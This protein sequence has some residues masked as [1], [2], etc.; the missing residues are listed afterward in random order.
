[1]DPNTARTR[2]LVLAAVFAAALILLTMLA[3]ALVAFLL[4]PGGPVITEP[5]PAPG[6]LPPPDDSPHLAL[7]NPSG[8]TADP[9]DRD[10]FLMRKPYFA[11]AYN[12]SR[13]TAN[14]VS[15]RLRPSDLGPAPR[16][17]FF[18][19]PDLPSSFWRITPRDYNDS[20]FDRG[21][22]CPR[23]DRSSSP[24]AAQATFVMTNIVPQAPHLNQKAW[25][26]FEDYCRDLAARR[27]Q[28]LYIVAGPQGRGGTGEKGPAETIAGGKVTVPA[29]CWKVVL[30][31]DGPEDAARVG[32]GARLIA[33]VMPNDQSVG[34]GWARYRTSV[35]AVEDLTGYRFFDRVPTTIIEPLKEPVDGGA[36]G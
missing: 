32:P 18:P 9:A 34:H 12:N 28:T 25:A 27:Q 24:E 6:T 21:H 35:R 16:G 29:R 2:K 7:G 4:R 5:E 14:W 1:M 23:G 8:A 33:V 30:A 31:L 17:Q 11:L 13:G 19:D 10:N 3:A 36:G 22:L 26:D 20:G 15:W